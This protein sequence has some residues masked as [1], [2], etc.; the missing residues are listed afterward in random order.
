MPIP[1]SPRSTTTHVAGA[2]V[3]FCAASRI[4]VCG[5]HTTG[6]I[7]KQRSAPADR[8]G[9]AP[10]A[11]ASRCSSVGGSSS[12]ARHEPQA[13]PGAAS[14]SCG[15]LARESGSRRCPR[16]RGSRTRAESPTAST[17]DR[18]ARPRRA[19]RARGR[20]RRSRPRRC[21][22]R[23]GARTGPSPWE[24]IVVPAGRHLEL[25]GARRRAPRRRPAATRTADGP[26]GSGLLRAPRRRSR[27]RPQAAAVEPVEP[28]ASVIEFASVDQ[29]ATSPIG[30][31]HG[32]AEPRPGARRAP[33]T[34]FLACT[35][36]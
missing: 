22:P 28:P 31:A 9:C 27:R 29:G 14:S 24:K 18:T 3:I 35:A 19:G 6:S 1:S 26:A 7:A 12:D 4:E 8:R 13:R 21:A 32:Q 10:A 2:A 36:K 20:R 16:R 23:A 15:H 11:R 17:P 33:P 30:G 25:G 5:P 34:G